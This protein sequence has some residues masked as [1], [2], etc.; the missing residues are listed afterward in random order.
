MRDAFIDFGKLMQ[1]AFFRDRLKM[2]FGKE[3]QTLYSRRIEDEIYREVRKD[4]DGMLSEW[5]K[6][7]QGKLPGISDL[8]RD[9]FQS[10]FSMNVK[11]KPE[12]VLSPMAKKFHRPILRQLMRSPVYPAI[13]AICEG[14]ELPAYDATEEF[15]RQIIENLDRLMDAANGPKQSLS[16]LEKETAKQEE[17]LEQLGELLDRR[18]PAQLDPKLEKKILRLANR[19][20]SK[21]RQLAALEKMVEDNLLRHQEQVESVLSAAG[22]AAMEKADETAQILLSWGTDPGNM[23]PDALNGQL[24]QKVRQN[25]QLVKISQYLGRLREMMRVKRKN[26]TVYGRGEKYGLELGNRLRS[27]ISSEF[28]PLAAPETIPLFLRKYQRGALL[29]HQQRERVCKGQGDKIVCLDESGSTMQNGGDNAAWGKAVAYAL[30]DI[31]RFHRRN[32]ALI[33]FADADDFRTDIFRPGQYVPEDVLSSASSFLNGGTDYEAPLREAFRLM[34]TGEFRQA[35]VVFIT[36]GECRVSESFVQELQKKKAAMGFTIT[37]IL[38][39]Q[40]SPGMKFTLAP[41]CDEI[42]R[43]SELGGQQVAERLLSGRI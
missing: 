35:D 30:L 26:A 34:D 27:V 37:G 10:L 39:D 3:N 9:V 1:S 19:T 20:H 31:T 25:G 32:F 2:V 14:N 29:Q 38:M 5:E 15:M 22:Q 17:R 13:R 8:S 4:R 42:Y 28:G 41:F 11:E 23:R 7:V 6:Q 33:H 24:L 16:V 40:A 36:D 12:D 43:I 21:V 18:D